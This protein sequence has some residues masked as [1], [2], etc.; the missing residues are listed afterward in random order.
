[1][2]L[3]KL[4]YLGYI[5]VVPKL[6][7]GFSWGQMFGAF[8]LLTVFASLHHDGAVVHPR[9]GARQFSRAGRRWGHAALVVASPH[10]DGW[11]LCD[12]ERLGDPLFGA[13]TTTSSI[14]CSN[15]FATSI[16]LR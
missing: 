14:T 9:G 8:V 12:R 6:V 16:I 13:S 7:L 3:F 15:T 5:V 2:V 1:M 4:G 10:A 11:G